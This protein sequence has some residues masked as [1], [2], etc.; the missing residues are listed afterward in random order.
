MKV[1]F[2]YSALPSSISVIYPT[3]TYHATIPKGD[4]IYS[5]IF[6]GDL[7]RVKALFADGKVKIT[8]YD[9]NGMNLLGVSG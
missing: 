4:E 8:D 9:E 2:S 7:I 1:I 6:R 5:A 3:L